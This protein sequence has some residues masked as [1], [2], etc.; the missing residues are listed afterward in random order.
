M[1]KL[2]YCKGNLD[3]ED[4]VKKIAVL[5]TS[6]PQFGGEHQYLVLLMEAIKKCDGRYFE[7]LGISGNKFWNDWCKKNNINYIKYQVDYKPEMVI[8]NNMRY[9]LGAVVYNILFD[10]LSRIIIRNRVKLLICGQQGIFLPKLPCK[11]LRPVHDLMH[12][13]EPNFPEIK[14]T[15]KEREIL[16][17]SV[18]RLADIILVDSE[19]GKQQFVE[20]YYCKRGNPKVEILPFV[21]PSHIN[22]LKEEYIETPD[23][24]IFYPAQ[25][26]EHKNH[27]NLIKAIALLKEREPDIKLVLVGA[28]KNSMQRVKKM[29]AE[30]KLENNVFIFGFV[31]DEQITYLYKHAVALVMPSYFGPTNIPPLEAMS[32][33]CPTI[34]SDKYAMKE[35]VGDAG[36]FFNP[37]IPEEIGE[38]ILRVWNSE[39]LRE[40]MKQRGYQKIQSWTQNDFKSKFI[41]IILR[42]LQ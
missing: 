17:S 27:V 37:D 18:A 34:V 24:Y 36:L 26:W 2:F 19:L 20:S 4:M 21:V 25:F 29:I 12:R 10:N 40:Q 11:V 33:G 22:K 15:I 35:Q 8:Q 5:L 23:K 38:S 6:V 14:S 42:E 1:D 3:E 41:K 9:P 30:R 28:E 16:F 31:S 13:Y 39:K 32:L 7:V